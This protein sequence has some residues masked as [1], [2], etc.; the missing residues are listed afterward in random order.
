MQRGFTLVELSIVLVIIGLI[1]GGVLGGSALIQQARLQSVVK[2]MNSYRVAYNTFQTKY[3]A[4]PGDFDE[5]ELYWPGEASDG[6]SN[7][8]INYFTAETSQSLV[9]LRLANIIQ[10]ELS[11]LEDKYI[12]SDIEGAALVFSGSNTPYGYR[13]V[14]GNRLKIG[15]PHPGGALSTGI[16]N[17]PEAMTIDKKIDDGKPDSG[18]MLAFNGSS[19]SSNTCTTGHTHWGSVDWIPTN[20][21]KHCTLSLQLD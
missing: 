17:T 14:L 12:H 8:I 18:K 4:A 10:T 5:A 19:S 15:A 9:H 11:H 21:E 3:N 20:L 6:N 16:L 7:G 1:A 2:D 13:Q